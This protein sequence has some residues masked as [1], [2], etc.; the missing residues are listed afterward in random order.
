[1]GGNDARENKDDKATKATTT[2][3]ASAA[4]TTTTTTSCFAALADEILR[5]EVSLVEVALGAFTAAAQS[6][7]LTTVLLQPPTTEAKA[8]LKQKK[9]ALNPRSSALWSGEQEKQL[10]AQV[11]AA[12]RVA[13]LFHVKGMG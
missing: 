2:S 12:H 9:A 8:L 13:L 1:L 11:K 6:P 5:V 3:D 7:S 4:T 10:T